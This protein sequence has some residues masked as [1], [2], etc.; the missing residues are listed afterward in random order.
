[1]H[2]FYFLCLFLPSTLFP[3]VTYFVLVIIPPYFVLSFVALHLFVSVSIF[4]YFIGF[5]FLYRFILLGKF[6]PSY[7]WCY[8]LFVVFL[9]CW[10]FLCT[11]FVLLVLI[12]HL[13]TATV[14]IILPYGSPAIVIDLSIDH[15]VYFS[16]EIVKLG[17]TMGKSWHRIFTPNY[18]WDFMSL[19]PGNGKPRPVWVVHWLWVH[20]PIY[21]HSCCFT[22]HL[23]EGCVFLSLD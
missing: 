23:C 8:L 1:M 19:R 13:F 16:V 12:G 11:I 18:P 9:C 14:S 21:I 20:P 15:R 7:P 10:H 5:N 2:L 6:D 4:F 17:S 3:L 22:A